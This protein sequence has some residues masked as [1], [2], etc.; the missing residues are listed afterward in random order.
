MAV[1]NSQTLEGRLGIP[2]KSG[3]LSARSL[4]T[5]KKADIYRS[6]IISHVAG[7][8]ECSSIRYHAVPVSWFIEEEPFNEELHHINRRRCVDL[9]A[10]W[11]RRT[12]AHQGFGITPRKSDRGPDHA[13]GR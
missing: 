3:N 9:P 10:Q 4:R 5:A 11:L 1:A 12:D 6:S 7:N 13:T 8:S 2:R